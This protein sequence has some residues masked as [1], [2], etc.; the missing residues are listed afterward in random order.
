MSPGWL[1]SGLVSLS[2]QQEGVCRAMKGE[3]E[4]N[5]CSWCFSMS[6]DL[7]RVRSSPEAES[8]FSPSALVLKTVSIWIWKEWKGGGG[9]ACEGLMGADREYR[10]YCQTESLSPLLISNSLSVWSRIIA[11]TQLEQS[12]AKLDP[13]SHLHCPHPLL[14]LSASLSSHA[15]WG[16]VLAFKKANL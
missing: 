10:G 2:T 3:E 14:S 8:M 16:G 4:V 5:K 12:G 9:G 15:T 1:L 13:L 6:S 11:L 7:V